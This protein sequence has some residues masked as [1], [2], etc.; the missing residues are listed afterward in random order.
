MSSRSG[1]LAASLFCIAVSTVFAHAD[2]VTI[3]DAVRLAKTYNGTIKSA[4]QE[5][6]AAK[7]RL[8]QAQSA[9]FPVLT[10]SLTYVDS[11]RGVPNPQFGT[12]TITFNQ[13]STEGALSWRVL[14]AG[15]RLA[16]IRAAR[17]SMF[18][19]NDQNALNSRQV[20]LTLYRNYVE[21]LRAQELEKIATSQLT[22]AETVLA[23][24]K[25]R[26]AVGD[27]AKREIL[28]AQADSLNASVNSIN[29]RNRVNT[30]LAGLKAVINRGYPQEMELSA[31]ELQVIEEN[32]T[33]LEHAVQ[34]MYAIRPQLLIQLN[35]FRATEEQIRSAE[36]DAG[37]TYALDYSYSK[38]FTPTS[39]FNQNVSF[40]ASF[41]LFD[42]GLRRAVVQE[43]RASY[44]SQKKQLDQT[45]RLAAGDV[46]VAY[47]NLQQNKKRFDAAKLARDAAQLNYEAA[48]ESQRL[49]AADLIEVL[50][51]QVSLVT[52]EA[53]LVEANYDTVLSKIQLLFEV[54][55][56][57]PGELGS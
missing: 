27:A 2:K 3:F 6:V 22:R 45:M 51:S 20:L 23:Q 34:M 49:G 10:P 17:Y 18:A 4:E 38:Q 46:E 26:V 31:S 14:D 33:S 21:S 13:T 35:N 11:Q 47:L 42:G 15:Q 55:F 30:N 36:I 43:R 19:Q 7:A 1:R 9:L 37:V 39:G 28:Q 8:R 53:N 5:M 52:A 44:D 48:I 54:G 50:T 41:P 16:Q 24:T 25:A 56:P 40:I 57:L 32:F 12:Q 29:A